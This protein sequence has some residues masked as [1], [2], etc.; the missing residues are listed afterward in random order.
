[1]PPYVENFFRRVSSQFQVRL[2]ITEAERVTNLL[3]LYTRFGPESPA[4]LGVAERKKLRVGGRVGS[5]N[6][7]RYRHGTKRVRV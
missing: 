1:M 5:R 3:L 2:K 4:A 7:A 6:F